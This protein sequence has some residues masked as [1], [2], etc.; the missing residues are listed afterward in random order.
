MQI[1]TDRVLILSS[2]GGSGHE[3]GAQSVEQ[4]LLQS[5]LSKDHIVKVDVMN[6]FCTGIPAFGRFCTR[7]W[8]NAQKTGNVKR[9]VLLVSGQ[10]LFDKMCFLSTYLYVYSLLKD[11]RHRP[12]RVILTSPLFLS[13]ICCAVKRVNKTSAAPILIDLY[14][15]EPPTDKALHFFD[16]IRNLRECQRNLLT[17]HVQKPCERDLQNC[18]DEEKY[19][20]TKTGLF[21]SQIMHDSPIKTHFQNSENLPMPGSACELKIT[22]HNNYEKETAFL[23]ELVKKSV[24]Q[25]FDAQIRECVFSIRSHDK[26]CLLMLGGIPTKKAILDY[27]DKALELAKIIENQGLHASSLHKNYLFVACGNPSTGL[28]EE[29]CKRLQNASVSSLIIVPFTGQPLE[30][31]FARADITIT[32]SGGMTSLEILALKKNTKRN[33][34]KKILIHSEAGSAA[35]SLEEFYYGKNTAMQKPFSSAKK[36]EGVFQDYNEYLIQKGIPLWEGSNAAY[37]IKEVAGVEIVTAKVISSYFK[38]AFFPSTQKNQVEKSITSSL[39]ERALSNLQAISL[40]KERLPK[41]FSKKGYSIL[42]GAA[43]AA[44]GT[45]FYFDSF[46]IPGCILA[47]TSILGLYALFA[48]DIEDDFADQHFEEVDESVNIDI[49]NPAYLD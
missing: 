46:F 34:P 22:A 27:V 13:A 36:A 33:D 10:W 12:T 38:N 31:V 19:W 3:Q 39:Q 23:R 8:D 49:I 43:I 24:A 11:S 35:L 15:T 25:S 9:Q 41:L 5:G 16:P 32:R 42:V 20:F 7:L 14:M 44:L 17:L 2:T 29:V 40:R 21:S 26:V 18:G 47:A 37:L 28:Y 4:V 30:Q 1:S 48:G 45:F 6:S